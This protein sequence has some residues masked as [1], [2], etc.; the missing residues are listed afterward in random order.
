MILDDNHYTL[1]DAESEKFYRNGLK[2]RLF[3][4]WRKFVSLFRE[5][6]ESEERRFE[7]KVYLGKYFD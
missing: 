7:S 1:Q 4:G 3:E 2:R 5:K 6:E